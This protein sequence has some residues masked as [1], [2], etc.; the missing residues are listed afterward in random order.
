MIRN[1]FVLTIIAFSS[2]PLFA[3]ESSF[4]PQVEILKWKYGYNSAFSFTFDDGLLTQYEY[5]RPVLEQYDFRGTFYV[6]P[7]FLTEN[8]PGIWRYGTWQMFQSMSWDN[9]EIGS[10]SLNHPYLTSLPAGDT[11]TQNTIHHELYHSRKQIELRTAKS[12][13]SLAYPYSDHNSIVD[14]LTSI[15]YQSGRSVGPLP[16]HDTPANWFGLSSYPVTFSLPRNS[17]SD[18]LDELNNFMVWV[19]NSI[20]DSLWGIIMI[21]EVV[22]FAQI[23]DLL[24]QGLYEPM[25]TEWLSLLCGWLQ[26][27]AYDS[28]VWVETVGNITKY[29]KER[30]NT[31]YE[32]LS[33][34]NDQMNFRMTHNLNTSIYNFPLTALVSVP[35]DWTNAYITQ[36][37]YSDSLE[38]YESH[39]GRTVMVNVVPDGSIFT[40][41]ENKLTD[42]NSTNPTLSSFIL[43]QNYPNPFNPTTNIKYTVGDA[44]HASPTWVTLRVYD[45]L[46]NEIATLVDEFKP[47]GNYEVEFS[48]LAGS[49][50]A[51]NATGL[52]SG[53]Y[54][55]RLQTE[56]FTETK[57]MILL[58]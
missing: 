10:H 52:A 33:V 6:L 44:Y 27:K 16:N 4:D 11:L 9:H 19:E 22:P 24:N 47:A 57:K 39:L 25:S 54:Y 37:S 40:V 5:A 36:G 28:E 42:I 55:Y 30:D 46:G 29:V 32:I 1:I 41:S 50:S 17:S 51:G 49:G 48:A 15:Y 34:T 23:A 14:S 8:L 45:V 3:Q 58:K 20:E 26:T 53:I 2:V 12:T 35:T 31:G 21:H 13:L 7:P 38:I 43:S 18:D 56:T